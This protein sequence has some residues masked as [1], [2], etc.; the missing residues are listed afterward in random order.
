LK[1]VNFDQP[2]PPVGA[3]D[4]FYAVTADHPVV[5]HDGPLA[6][7]QELSQP[8][9]TWEGYSFPG[10]LLAGVAYFFDTLLSAGRERPQERRIA[11]AFCPYTPPAM[12]KISAPASNKVFTFFLPDR[13]NRSAA[14]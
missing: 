13:A 6:A 3:G 10:L 11:P 1:A 12:R 7:Q 5:D 4:S 2:L 14:T 8:R 9:V